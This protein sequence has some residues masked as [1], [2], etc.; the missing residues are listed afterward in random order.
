MNRPGFRPDRGQRPWRLESYVCRRRLQASQLSTP[1]TAPGR[2]PAGRH[3]DRV[4]AVLLVIGIPVVNVCLQGRNAQAGAFVSQLGR[5]GAISH[6][7][8]VAHAALI[9]IKADKSQNI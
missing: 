7:Q 3:A 5:C 1:A 6:V 2:P 8:Y 4:V 9:P